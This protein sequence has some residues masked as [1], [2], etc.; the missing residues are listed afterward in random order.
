M[1]GDGLRF[2]WNLYRRDLGARHAQFDARLACAVFRGMGGVATARQYR[3][4][5][6][7]ADFPAGARRPAGAALPRAAQDGFRGA[8]T[9][10][11][12]AVIIAASAPTISDSDSRPVRRSVDNKSV[13]IA[14]TRP[15]PLYTSDE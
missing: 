10:Q 9:G 15:R 8:H 2:R 11:S 3:A 5:A 7:A 4:V 6:C 14:S 1:R 13:L 12:S